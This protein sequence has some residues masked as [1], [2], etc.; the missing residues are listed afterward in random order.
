MVIIVQTIKATLI[1]YNYT[2][3]DF[4]NSK[5]TKIK[6]VIYAYKKSIS[7][8]EFYQAGMQGL[9]PQFMLLVFF[10]DYQGEDTVEI[11]G[12]IYY[13]YRTYINKY[14]EIELYLT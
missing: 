13:I 7:Q 12:I 5:K 1:K 11:D 3:D 4:G 2:K 8:S 10:G 9:K 6:K 14:E